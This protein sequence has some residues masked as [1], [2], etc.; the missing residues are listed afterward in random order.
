MKKLIFLFPLLAAAQ[1]VPDGV[2]FEKDVV[3]SPGNKLMMDVARPKSPGLHPAVVAIHGG[4]F[5][6]GERSAWDTSILRLAQ[7][8]Y[9]GVT[10]DYRLAPKIQFPA[11][12]QDIKAA[13]R[14][15]RANAEKYAIDPERFA[16][17]GDSAG[18]NLALML[19]F[20]PGVAD[21][22]GGGNRDQSSRV[23]CVVAFYS[24]SDFTRIYTTQAIRDML[25]MYLGGSLENAAAVHRLASPLYW[26]TP[27]APPVLAIH[28]TKDPQVRL[29]QSQWLVERLKQAGATAELET[30]EGGG[31]GFEGAD[32]ERAERR[33]IEFLDRHL[34]MKPAQQVL[35][36][37][38]HGARGQIVA[39]EW[40][41]G[42][43][44]WTVPNHNGHDVQPL[45]GGH[46]LYT[47]NPERKVVEMDADHKPVWTYGAE[48][49]LQ[50]P[51]SA[52]RLPN[53]NT[54]I[55]D[56]QLGR[57]IEIDKDRNIVWK[58]ESADLA[59]MRMRNSANREREHADLG[60]GRGQDHRSES[61]RRDRVELYRG[62]RPESGDRIRR[63]ACRTATR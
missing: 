50:H 53:G 17:V 10:V 13:V 19:G 7:H 54:L 6:G 44:L 48:E 42:R 21:F 63:C 46:V 15:L 36:V 23:S 5:F 25:P 29:E 12:L 31:H 59:N 33:M 52:Q 20:T 1:T 41:S 22:E 57:V 45:P 58:Y 11:P 18:A 55:G 40:P 24:P 30:I 3:Y 56:A 28:G 2:T 4:G 39:M 35:L 9:V 61:R 38:D 37:S 34:G 43:E 62:G 14:F 51:I 27:Q 26:V 16:A 60:G 32:A 47:I 49:G 8:G